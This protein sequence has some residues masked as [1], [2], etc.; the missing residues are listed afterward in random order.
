M[1]IDKYKTDPKL[2]KMTEKIIIF[3][4]SVL[5]IT[6]VWVKWR[7]N[8]LVMNAPWSGEGP[9]LNPS[10][11]YS[12][13]ISAHLPYHSVCSLS[14]VPL[15]TPVHSLLLSLL[16]LHWALGASVDL[17]QL[18]PR[19]AELTLRI[20]HCPLAH[21]DDQYRHRLRHCCPSLRPHYFAPS[22]SAATHTPLSSINVLYCIWLWCGP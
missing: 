12:S 6:I 18:H 10:S 15:P 8:Y 14:Y 3:S 2:S 4:L 19:T 21:P 22:P 5:N 13:P 20:Q 17:T 7:N 1:K 9:H 16:S 11:S